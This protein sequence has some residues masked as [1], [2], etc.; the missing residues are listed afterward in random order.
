MFVF[1]GRPGKSAVLVRGCSL[2]FAPTVAK[3]VAIRGSSVDGQ[4]GH[5][6]PIVI[7]LP[8]MCVPL[9]KETVHESAERPRSTLRV[10]IR[11]KEMAA[12][13]GKDVA[14]ALRD[15][16]VMMAGEAAK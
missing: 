5:C 3:T 10:P 15:I 13:V 1:P 8:Y 9:Y 7:A 16:A 14:E 2:V 4:S 11:V 12:E 6:P